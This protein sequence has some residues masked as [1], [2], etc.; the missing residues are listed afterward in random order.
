MEF[1]RSAAPY[2]APARRLMDFHEIYTDHDD[3]RLRT[4]GSRCMDC[5]VPFC[6]SNDG[7]PIHN[8]I[9]SW[10]D[11]VYR[12][13]WRDALEQLHQ[14]NN[15]PEFTGR[16]CPAP[17]EGSCV[18]GIT[19]PAVTIKNIEMA[20]IDRGFAEGWVV[21]QPPIHRTGKSTAIVG[22]G[23]AGLSAAAQLNQA[24]HTV[25]VY[26]RADRPGGL[27][28]YGIPNMKLAKNEIVERRI[29]LLRDEG[30]SFVTNTPIA[31]GANGSLDIRTLVEDSDAVLLST[32]A[33]A[34]RDLSI[35]G[36]NLQGVHFAMEFLTLNTRSLLDSNLEDGNHISARGKDV[37]VIGGG[38]TGTDCIGTALRH[39]CRSLVNF[40]LF[41]RPPDSRASDNPW[42]TWPRIFRVEYGHEESAHKFG[43]DPR[44]YSISSVNFIDDGNGNVKG[45]RTVRVE[46]K[47]GKFDNV[48]GT[49]KNW[50]ADLIFLAMGFLGP[51]H[52]VSDPLGIEY[53][54]RSNYQAD[55]GRYA[56]SRA[57]VFAA[58]DCR[59]G[60]SLVVWAINEG[61]EAAREI[62]RYLM[63]STGLPS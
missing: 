3:Q 25:T 54:E 40:E 50:P 5:G 21:P 16:V 42:P 30:V 46:M 39:D 48:A 55:Y 31:D 15:F 61:R 22:S 14:T 4:Q 11:L 7:C 38:D 58:G 10:N 18:L 17:C 32:G 36:R 34:P 29:Q 43:R 37:I 57:E 9:P 8:L 60:Q 26:E 27:L 62:D 53:D 51:E 44:V 2:R 41:P 28:M 23:P 35:P 49:E 12:G 45:V 1:E 63:G 13:H 6:Q 56:T 24:G 19:D 33:T 47:N 59:R 52:A 20:I